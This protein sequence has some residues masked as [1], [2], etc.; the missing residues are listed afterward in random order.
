M[1]CLKSSRSVS[2][3]DNKNF[4]TESRT[5]VKSPGPWSW[6]SHVERRAANRGDRRGVTEGGTNTPFARLALGVLV[7]Q[8]TLAI[9][10]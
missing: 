1:N 9:A 8:E 10:S 4:L 6:E 3:P 7:E 2:F 5:G